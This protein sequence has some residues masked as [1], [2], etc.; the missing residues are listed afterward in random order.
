MVVYYIAIKTQYTSFKLTFEF[1]FKSS[2]NSDLIIS[3][4]FFFLKVFTA[5]LLKG[6]KFSLSLS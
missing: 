6:S 5:F 2:K 3:L 4:F 1:R